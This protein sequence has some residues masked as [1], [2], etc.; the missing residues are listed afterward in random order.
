MR[1]F[2]Y[3]PPRLA[4]N[5]AIDFIVDGHI[6]RGRCLNMSATGLSAAFHEEVQP[7]S[8]GTLILRHGAHSITL[9]AT[10]IHLDTGD[11]GLSFCF[12]N[13]EESARLSEFLTGAT[14]PA[15]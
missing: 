10:A 5:I 4:C 15:L 2:E 7:G 14:S 11:L 8:C 12:Q 9:A 6:H 3:R 13:D 1:N